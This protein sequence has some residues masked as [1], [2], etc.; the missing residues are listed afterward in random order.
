MS[1]ISIF[2]LTFIYSEIN[3]EVIEYKYGNLKQTTFNN[4]YNTYCIIK[5]LIMIF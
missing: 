5:L 1:F 4:N 3:K 2:I